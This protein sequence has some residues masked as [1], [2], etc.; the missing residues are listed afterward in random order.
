MQLLKILHQADHL[1]EEKANE[2]EDEEIKKE[3]ELL[4]LE[5][6]GVIHLLLVGHGVAAQMGL[7]L[8]GPKID[9]LIIRIGNSPTLIP[10]EPQE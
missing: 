10:G 7:S 2:I 4:R 5:T 1:L 3:I 9:D 8:L 6:K